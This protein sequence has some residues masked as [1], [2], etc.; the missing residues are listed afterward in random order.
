VLIAFLVARGVQLWPSYKGTIYQELFS[1][2]L[3]YFWRMRF[4]HDLSSS[5]YLK[6]KIGNHRIVYNAILGKKGSKLA[7]FVTVFSEHGFVS[8]C[9]M[10]YKGD[11][12]SS[13]GQGKWKVMQQGKTVRIPSPLVL[14]AQQKQFLSKTIGGDIPINYVIAFQNG[15]TFEH[16]N[17]SISVVISKDAIEE[18]CNMREGGVGPDEVNNAFEAFR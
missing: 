2:F 9:S 18:L 1:S 16:V 5:S 10:P 8:I 12:S 17:S 7:D 13:A 3:E 15:S 14:M 11:I 6:S 4:Q